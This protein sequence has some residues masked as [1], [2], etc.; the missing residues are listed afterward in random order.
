[1]NTN[2]PQPLPL[3]D[4]KIPAAVILIG[5]FEIAMA[6][7]GIII[8]I[9]FGH[10]DA[11]TGAYVVLLLVYGTMGAGLLAIQEWARFTNVV[12]H[13]IAI[14]YAFYTVA[15]LGA[16]SDWRLASQLLISFVIVFAL[17]R[18][19]MRYKFQTVVP[20]KKHHQ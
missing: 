14:P 19:A 6:L 4:K 10:L 12:L 3:P 1:L 9:L 11:G 7:L 5:S 20:K 15:F 2:T 18:P 16:P 8:V 13:L 17:T